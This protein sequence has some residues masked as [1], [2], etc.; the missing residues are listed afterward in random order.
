MEIELT[1]PTFPDS[2]LSVRQFDIVE[3]LSTPFEVA[4]VC[5]SGDANLDLE[6]IVGQP[7]SLRIANDMQASRK[8]TGVC[9][10]VEQLE[11]EPAGQSTYTLRI[12]PRL[13]LL[14]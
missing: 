1:L 3:G 7:A 11:A 13:W 12:V 4:L 14:S 10:Y 5:M 2:G 8:W 9:S 6:K